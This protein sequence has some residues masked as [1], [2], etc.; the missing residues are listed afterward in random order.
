M[1]KLLIGVF[2]VAAF[3]YAAYIVVL[4]RPLPELARTKGFK[5]RFL[6]T[7]MVFVGLMFAILNFSDAGEARGNETAASPPEE[8]LGIGDFI[9]LA[10]SIWQGLD[11]SKIESFDRTVDEFSSSGAFDAKVASYLKL[12]YAEMARHKAM[13]SSR[14]TCYMMTRA[15]G[16]ARASRDRLKTQLE[17]VDKAKSEGRLTPETAEVAAKAIAKE[18][19]TISQ[20]VLPPQKAG[21]TRQPEVDA[22]SAQKA[23]ELIVELQK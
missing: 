19:E 12:A 15:G 7:A 22:A 6:L 21:G 9:A 8:K 23:A 4:R 3:A 1:S 14:V 16:D 2:A 20:L 18:L 10:N 5:R 17:I 13:T 11:K